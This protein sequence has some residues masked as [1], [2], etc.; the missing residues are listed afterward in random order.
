MNAPFERPLCIQPIIG[1]REWR[2]RRT[3]Q[4]VRLV[5]LYTCVEWEPGHPMTG[6]PLA[7]AGFMEPYTPFGV[8]AW[9]Y[10]NFSWGDKKDAF[11]QGTVYL[12]GTVVEHVHGY[13]AQYA[14]PR[15]LVDDGREIVRAL[16]RAY[17]CELIP[18]P[19]PIK[20]SAS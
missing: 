16:A 11:V 7:Q 10:P 12:W 18:S 20:E 2:A 1:W 5:S 19:P 6:D 8:Y 15:A 3:P 14:Y 4:G 13:R 9:R 17:G